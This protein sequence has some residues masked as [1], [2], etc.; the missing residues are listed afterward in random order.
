MHFLDDFYEKSVTEKLRFFYYLHLDLLKLPYE[1]I[2]K[3]LLPRLFNIQLWEDPTTEFFYRQLLH[4]IRKIPTESLTIPDFLS[5][6]GTI[7]DHYDGNAEQ[8]SQL[9]PKAPKQQPLVGILMTPEYIPTVGTFLKT[10][11]ATNVLPPNL[12]VSASRRYQLRVGLMQQPL[13][14]SQQHGRSG[15]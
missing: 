6:E 13:R 5:I 7:D 14:T 4:P 8:G 3:R 2:Q 9:E 1:V 12:A 15:G 10:I 11:L